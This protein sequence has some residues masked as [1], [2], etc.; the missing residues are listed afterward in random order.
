M[1]YWISDGAYGEEYEG[2]A[3]DAMDRA[4]ELLE[5]DPFEPEVAMLNVYDVYRI[6]DGGDHR[7][8]IGSVERVVQPPE[9]KCVQ[10]H[11]HEWEYFGP[12]ATTV[13]G[14]GCRTTHVCRWCA[15][16]RITDTWALD[17]ATGR[18]LDEDALSY[19]EPGYD[20]ITWAELKRAEREK[21]GAQ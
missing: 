7:E 8:L 18:L 6:E 5:D 13:N 10:G 16:T 3:Q 21:E 17:P 2:D 15:W 20:S 19:E 14:G 11:E 9:P 12:T 1:K 4:R